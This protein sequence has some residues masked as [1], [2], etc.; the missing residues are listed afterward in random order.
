VERRKRLGRRVYTVPQIDEYG[1]FF[2]QEAK[3]K[4]QKYTLDDYARDKAKEFL[5]EMSREFFPMTLEAFRPDAQLRDTFFSNLEHLGIAANVY[6]REISKKSDGTVTVRASP[7]RDV[8]LGTISDSES[9][10]VTVADTDTPPP[11]Y[12]DD[13]NIVGMDDNY[14]TY[15]LS[16]TSTDTETDTETETG[17]ETDTETITYADIITTAVVFMSLGGLAFVID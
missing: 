15:L 12:D 4:G 14:E 7:F 3:R 13:G 11:V 16:D 2:V 10:S 5:S 8:A 17:T 9:V 6:V 1:Y